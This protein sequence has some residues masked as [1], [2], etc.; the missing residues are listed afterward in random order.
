MHLDGSNSFFIECNG[1]QINYSRMS[2][3]SDRKQLTH[4]TSCVSVPQTT[5]KLTGMRGHCSLLTFP[6]PHL[7]TLFATEPCSCSCFGLCGSSWHPPRDVNNCDAL[8]TLMGGSSHMCQL[9]APAKLSALGHQ[10]KGVA[11]L[12]KWY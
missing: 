4:H 10:P 3:P 2:L 9:T 8:Q 12:Q 6:Q 7:K 5:D 11:V 1:S